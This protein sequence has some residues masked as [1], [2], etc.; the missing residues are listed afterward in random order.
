MTNSGLLT[1]DV[2]QDHIWLFLIQGSHEIL[3]NPV[4][5]MILKD[6]FD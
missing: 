1:I 4:N 5:Q 6:P 2:I 3:L